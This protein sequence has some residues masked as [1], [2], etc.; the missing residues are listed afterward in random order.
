MQLYAF[1]PNINKWFIEISAP[2]L[3]PEL[4]RM[5]M[6]QNEAIQREPRKIDS[7]EDSGN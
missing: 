7:T 6:L 5:R 4:Q 1:P 3:K 2:D